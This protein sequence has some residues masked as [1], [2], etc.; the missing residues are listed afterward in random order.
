MQS[1]YI[2]GTK[3]NQVKIEPIKLDEEEKI[4]V[5]KTEHEDQR[6]VALIQYKNE[7]RR[8]IILKEIP[9]NKNH[10]KVVLLQAIQ[11]SGLGDEAQLGDVV[12]VNKDQI[13]LIQDWVNF[14]VGIKEVIAKADNSM[15]NPKVKYDSL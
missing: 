2:N 3:Y 13:D 12:Q 8:A 4:V 15:M 5:T 1:K 9:V 11:E 6:F 7:E 14:K 10:L